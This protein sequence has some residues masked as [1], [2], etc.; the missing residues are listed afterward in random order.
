VNIVIKGSP[1][2]QRPIAG[3]CFETMSIDKWPK[4]I[5]RSSDTTTSHPD[6]KHQVVGFRP[7]RR[8]NDTLHG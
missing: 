1:S 6:H 7:V 5:Y 8:T 2:I 3:F 4:P